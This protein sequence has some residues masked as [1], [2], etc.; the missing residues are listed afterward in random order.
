MIGARGLFGHYTADICSDCLGEIEVDVVKYLSVRFINN[1][2]I[3][4]TEFEGEGVD[5]MSTFIGC[6][7][8]DEELSLVEMLLE[9][10]S[11]SAL[12][13]SGHLCSEAWINF[14]ISKS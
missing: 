12:L 10:G 3:A 7:R 1:R 8:V 13:D 4:V 11:T 14:I 6:K 2:V 5:H 9:F